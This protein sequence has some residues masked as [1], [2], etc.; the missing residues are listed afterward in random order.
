MIINKNAQNISFVDV[1]EDEVTTAVNLI[2][3]V[4]DEFMGPAWEKMKQEGEEGAKLV[5][6]RAFAFVIATGAFHILQTAGA[7]DQV[8]EVITEAVAD[9]ATQMKAQLP[10]QK[11]EDEGIKN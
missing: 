5:S 1:G 10:K 7:P 9:V 3:K 4:Y 8:V 6:A 11:R 2:Q